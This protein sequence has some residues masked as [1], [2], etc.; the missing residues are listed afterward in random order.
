MTA[1]PRNPK[2]GDRFAP[3]PTTGPAKRGVVIVAVGKENVLY[4]HPERPDSEW[5]MRRSELERCYVAAPEPAPLPPLVDG[6]VVLREYKLHD[7]DERYLSESPHVV[8]VTGRSITLVDRQHH[9][10]RVGVERMAAEDAGRQ[11]G[12]WF[13][14]EASP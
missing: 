13:E 9:N 3:K 7:P 5:T 11:V 6:S 1:D 10:N 14:N 8:R 2:V 4:E 12:F